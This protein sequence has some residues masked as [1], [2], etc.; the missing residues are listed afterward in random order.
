M[1]L[2]NIIRAEGNSKYS[3]FAIILGAVL[4]IILD[5]IFILTFKMGVVGAA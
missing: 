4:N 1:T 5:P 2:N 3:A